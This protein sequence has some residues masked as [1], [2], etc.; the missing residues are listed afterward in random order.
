MGGLRSVTR[1][2]LLTTPERERPA[3]PGRGGCR[4]ALPASFA[5]ANRSGAA[6]P[7]PAG[8]ASAGRSPCGIYPVAHAFSHVLELWPEV[9]GSCLDLG[10]EFVERVG[11]AVC[12]TRLAA[13]PRRP[14]AGRSSSSSSRVASTRLRE[15]GIIVRRCATD[16]PRIRDSG[17]LHTCLLMGWTRYIYNRGKCKNASTN[18]KFRG[19]G[20][21]RTLRRNEEIGVAA[22]FHRLGLR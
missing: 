13:T 7:R 14:G 9:L 20:L 18:V 10:F 22:R 3:P 16:C 19:L 4:P 1:G 15:G 17:V 11:L 6:S 12:A 2:S 5:A 8:P 21:S